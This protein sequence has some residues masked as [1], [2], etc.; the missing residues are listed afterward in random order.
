MAEHFL[1]ER[2]K[3]GYLFNIEIIIQD[4]HRM[5]SIFLAS[6]HLAELRTDLAGDPIAYLQQ[7]EEDEITRILINSAITARIID[8]LDKNIFEQANTICGELIENL[9]NPKNTVPLN[10]REA[11][12]KIIHAKKIN[13]DTT[14]INNK[15]YKNPLLYFYGNKNGIKWKASLNVFDYVIK[16]IETVTM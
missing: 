5:M 13:Y 6:P 16:Y 4:L 3:S 11:C 9:D 7:Y 12:N 10:L 8:D 15:I 2:F 1:S 14:E